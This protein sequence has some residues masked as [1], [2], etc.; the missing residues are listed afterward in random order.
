MRTVLLLVAT[1]ALVVGCDMPTC[2]NTCR[3]FYAEDECNAPP[4]GRSR[5]EVITE[6]I[7]ACNEALE[8]PG[9]APDPHDAR[10]DPNKIP[11][12]QKPVLNNEKEV[13]AWMDCVWSFSDE[14]CDEAL[15]K[16]CARV[17]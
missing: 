1:S 10:F 9:P 14:E 5:D 11:P 3:R 6:C 2:Q 8:V 16:H 12:P 15:Q 7:D 4:A 17:P 13:G